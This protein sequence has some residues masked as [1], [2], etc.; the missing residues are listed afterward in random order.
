MLPSMPPNPLENR[1]IGF[2]GVG[3]MASAMIKGLL[4]SGISPGRISAADPW[5]P[6][7]AKWKKEG[8]NVTGNVEC[9]LVSE[10]IV[11][12]VKPD[13]VAAVLAPLDMRGKLVISIAAGVPLMAIEIAAGSGA[14]CV[15]T[16]P[17]T[18]CLVGEAAVGVARGSIA[19]DADVT[20]AIAL[21]RGVVVEVPE[22]LLNAVT[23]LSGS[24][25]AYVFLM[26][27]AL[28]D[29]GVK[30]GLPRATALKLAAQ[31]VKGSAALQLATGTHPGQL[32]DQVCSPGGTT[33]AG[34]AA[35]EE[36]GFRAA[37]I[38]AV[39][40]AKARADEMSSSATK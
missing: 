31:T 15:R 8:L 3:A 22:K 10:I 30:A 5:E 35:L 21:F 27:E 16:M 9:A 26:I 11:V 20:A 13:M 2:L 34:V 25:P 37:A 12:A 24:G 7:R 33:I 32:K 28:A 38:A 14:R 19:M 23:A 29:G 36:H 4:L 40:A 17:N 39:T 1:N 6:A 18:P